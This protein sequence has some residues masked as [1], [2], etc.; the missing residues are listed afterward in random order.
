MGGGILVFDKIKF[1]KFV[2][3]KEFL[4]DSYTAFI[5]KI[6]LT[7]NDQYLTQSTEVVLDFPF[8]D[9]ILEG[10]QTKE[11]KQERQEIFWNQTLASDEIDLLR[12]PKVFT[13]WKRYDKDG[14][15]LVKNLDKEHDG[16]LKDNLIIKGNNLIALH[17]IKKIYSGKVKL[18]YIDPPYNTG[19]DGFRYNDNFKRPTWLTFMKNRLEIARKLL[20]DDGIIAVHIDDNEQAYLKVLMDEI[21]SEFDDNFVNQFIWINKLAGRQ[22]QKIGAVTTKEYLL[23]YA[24]NVKNINQFRIEKEIAKSLMPDAYKNKN[25]MP[26]EKADDR[27]TITRKGKGAKPQY[28]VKTDDRGTYITQSELQNGNYKEFNEK[29]RPNLVF[30]IFYNPNDNRV[31]TGEMG[32]KLPSGFI[33]IPPKKTSKGP[34]KFYVWRWGRSK[35]ESDSF[36]L[37]FLE[38]GGEWKVFTKKRNFQ[39]TALKDIITNIPTSRGSNHL[40]NIGMENTFSHSKPEELPYIF[41]KS[42]TDQ[43]DI[44]L[45]FFLGSGTTATAAHKMRR[46]YIGIEQMDY[47]ENVAVKRLKEVIRGEPYGVSETLKWKGGGSFV[48]CK[49][50][51]NMQNYK[52]K[53]IRADDA[54][55]N[56]IYKELKKSPYVSYQVKFQE[57]SDQQFEKLTLMDKRKTLNSILDQNMLYV[58]YSERDDEDFQIQEIDK[59]ITE[60]FYN[61]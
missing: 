13:N 49:L 25:K 52:N 30:D 27:R 23:L 3:N 29:T 35:V 14:E 12:E 57:I 38:K 56:L 43:S 32:E 11:K 22:T 61:E 21:F 19:N 48:Y 54:K 59:K 16:T 58:D 46:R 34:N 28:D 9:C 40:A 50:A 36:D 1:Q 8:K 42:I 18:I 39:T 51:E 7:A 5:N 24:K 2:T 15:K 33:R 55:A 53:I 60:Q 26:D 31:Q 41:I 37:E 17:S 10:G 47:I 20:S 4:A 45:D 6:G 44:I